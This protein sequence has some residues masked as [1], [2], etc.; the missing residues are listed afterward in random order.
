MTHRAVLLEA[1][2]STPADIARLARGLD[3]AA[4]ARRPEGGRSCRDLIAQ[5]SYSEEHSRAQFRR[6]LSEDAPALTA[7]DLTLAVDAG[8]GMA[9]LVEQFARAR[10]ETLAW[11]S[12]LGPG[13]WQRPAV[14]PTGGRTTLRFLVGE[15]VASDIA[16]TNQLVTVRNQW[17]AARP[18][19][20][21]E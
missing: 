9:V 12:A 18:E 14:H 19:V 21:D 13:A 5:L 2:A 8:E 17:R 6:I 11:L 7:P 3:E 16:L 4:A 1:L 20:T 15:L 10:A